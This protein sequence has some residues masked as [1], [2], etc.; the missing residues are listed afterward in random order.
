VEIFNLSLPYKDMMKI[1]HIDLSDASV[2]D[3]ELDATALKLFGGGRGLGVVLL[4]RNMFDGEPLEP[5]SPLVFSVGLLVGTPF[6]LSNRLSMVFRSPLTKTVAW[7]QTGG[8]AGSAL[9]GTGYAALYITGRSEKLSYLIVSENGIKV[10]EAEN[11]KGLDA[12]TTCSVL[13]SVHGDARVVAA[14][15]AGERCVP[16][17]TVVND[18]G[19]SSGV[20]HGVGAL[21]GSKNLK[22]VVFKTPKNPP[23]VVKDHA[24]FT[25]LLKRLQEKFRRSSLLNHDKGLLALYGTPI[26]AEALGRNH[27]LPVK[28]YQQ[29]YIEGFDLVGGRAMFSKNLLNRLTCSICPVS[30]RRETTGYGVRTE[31]PDYAQISSLGTNCML[32]D[33]E[34]ITYLTHMCYELG[35]DPIEAGNTIAVYSQL[36][37]EGYVRE[38]I[39]W[40]SFETMKKLLHDMAYGVGD[41]AVLGRGAHETAVY[42]NNP[43]ASPSVKGISVQNA[44]PR[45]EPAWGLINAVESFGG[46]V[47]IWVYPRLIRSFEELN[48]N[49]IYQDNSSTEQDIAEK[50]YLEQ[51]WVAAA[52]SLGVCA[53]SRLAFTPTDYVDGVNILRNLDLTVETLIDIGKNILA[54]ERE[55]NNLYGFDSTHDRLPRKFTEV[56][57]PSG[58]HA[59]T[60][61]EISSLLSP[62]YMTRKDPPIS[63]L[64]S[65]LPRLS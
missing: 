48:V 25:K 46:G 10:A 44:D 58:K 34:K 40:G 12:V 43:D 24:W 22:A 38:R 2:E 54:A 55:L 39:C 57:V 49:T 20:R 30:C 32:L 3:F 16:I 7:A 61:C 33:L 19:R 62:Y 9:A 35:L 63:K 28:N 37:D 41:G 4:R 27:A 17:A 21:M 53:F 11:L 65:S 8:Y 6:P 56:E 26:A 5:R 50:V 64:L 18:M 15:P 47:H 51:V 14:G 1:A 45:A 29:T 36:S 31:G 60:K 52:D 13:K 42:F 23:V 59:G